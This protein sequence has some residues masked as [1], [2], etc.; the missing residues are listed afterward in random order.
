LI[1]PPSFVTPATRTARRQDDPSPAALDSG[2]KAPPEPKQSELVWL[3]PNTLVNYVS[4]GRN[5]SSWRPVLNLTGSD[6][7]F[8]A[9]EWTTPGLRRDRQSGSPWIRLQMR[10]G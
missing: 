5:I 7:H 2:G 1:C 6:A 4:G 9:C 10:Q 3:W 8:V